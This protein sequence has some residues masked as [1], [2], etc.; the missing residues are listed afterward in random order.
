MAGTYLLKMH[1]THDCILV[2]F[3]LSLS[4]LICWSQVFVCFF[5]KMIYFLLFVGEGEHVSKLVDATFKNCIS[6]WFLPS[7]NHQWKL[8]CVYWLFLIEK[9]K[10]F[11][12]D[13]SWKNRSI[14]VNRR[15]CKFETEKQRNDVLLNRFH[16]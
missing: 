1:S 14:F 13:W 5:F 4:F 6:F 16:I 8:I 15:I 12:A 2:I 10:P 9:K 7:L 11:C 3:F